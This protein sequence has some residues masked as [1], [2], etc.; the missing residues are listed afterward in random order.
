MPE[1]DACGY[2]ISLKD[3][4]ELWKFIK[5][6]LSVNLKA[7]EF[8]SVARFLARVKEHIDVDFESDVLPNLNG[9]FRVYSLVSIS[10]IDG[11]DIILGLQFK[12][13]ETPKTLMNLIKS[14]K[15]GKGSCQGTV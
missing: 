2:F 8:N 3:P 7:D 12:D 1:N 5:G 15:G 13:A 10:D 14:S 9:V 11:L 4:L 6:Q